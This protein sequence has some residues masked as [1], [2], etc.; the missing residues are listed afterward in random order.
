MIRTNGFFYRNVGADRVVG[1]GEK[2]GWERGGRKERRDGWKERGGGR[3]EKVAGRKEKSK[4]VR[5]ETR[6]GRREKRG[7]RKEKSGGRREKGPT[8]PPPPQNA[9]VRHKPPSPQTSPPPNYK[10]WHERTKASP[11]NLPPPTPTAKLSGFAP[12]FFF[13]R[14]HF[15]QF[16]FFGA[17]F[18]KFGPF[19]TSHINLMMKIIS[20]NLSTWGCCIDF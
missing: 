18:F 5:K 10:N 8:H 4:G 13:F 19:I 17:N 2:W 15:C 11:P 14:H 6:G 16:D 7:G 3:K 9:S 1:A 20:C 12:G